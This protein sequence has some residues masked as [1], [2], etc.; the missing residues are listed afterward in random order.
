MSAANY[1]E[2]CGECSQRIRVT[3]CN[4]VAQAARSGHCEEIKQL[5]R[6]GISDF[7]LF[8]FHHV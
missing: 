2:N 5:I 7:C 4:T 3:C 8:I 1:F 6:S